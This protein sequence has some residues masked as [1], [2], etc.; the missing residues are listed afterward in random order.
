MLHHIQKTVIDTLASRKSA[1]YGELKPSDMDGNQFTYHLKQLVIDKYVAQNEDGTYSL[2]KK[3]QGYLVRRYEDPEESAHT[4]FLIIIRHGDKLLL[5]RRRVQPALG[6]V[7]F[8]H[9]EPL[10]SEPLDQTVN[11]RVKLKTGLDVSNISVVGSGLIRMYDG[12]QVE[13]FSHAIIITADAPTDILSVTQD[14]TGENFWINENEVDMV[15]NI[16]PSCLDILEL[17]KTQPAIW[18][19]KTY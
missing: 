13:S 17:I 14:Q 12:D 5:R 8:V 19:D 15:D 9:G 1:R 4:I 2:T 6:K 18:F 10:A 16:I 7:G 11:A 3:G